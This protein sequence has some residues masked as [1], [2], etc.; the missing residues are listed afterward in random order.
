MSVRGA[1]VGAVVLNVLS[2]VG[3]SMSN[4]LALAKAGTELAPA[5]TLLHFLS[6]A[7]YVWSFSRTMQINMDMLAGLHVCL[8]HPLSHTFQQ[9]MQRITSRYTGIQVR[10]SGQE[11]AWHGKHLG[12]NSPRMSTMMLKIS[13]VAFLN[14]CSVVSAFQCP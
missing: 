10:S 11:F 13:A 14:M 5:L 6:T 3:V 7:L 4:K 2:S 1:F 12:S 8:C 9:A